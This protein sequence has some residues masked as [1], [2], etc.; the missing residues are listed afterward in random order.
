MV[1]VPLLNGTKTIAMKFYLF[2]FILF[3]T[4]LFGQSYQ[5]LERNKNLKKYKSVK[6]YNSDGRKGW[7]EKIT[8]KGGRIHSIKTYNRSLL[9]HKAVYHFDTKGNLDYEI[10]KYNSNKGKVNDT[11]KHFNVYNEA[12]QLIKMGQEKRS[13]FTH[14][15]LPQLIERNATAF[16]SVFGYREE[17]TYDSI[18]NIRQHKI[19]TKSDDKFEIE[20]Q[21]FQYDHN[22]NVIELN[23]SA[24]PKQEY[25]IIMTGGRDHYENEKFRYVY[26]KDN[27]WVEKYWIIHNKEY[28]IAT[29]K[30]K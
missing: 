29:R 12:G 17:I 9:T 28:L 6:V 8:L 13:Q 10:E 14:Q 26:N 3:T 21:Q 15:N 18:G 20:I 7:W 24:I 23:R 11:V 5:E 1:S 19:Y 22:N 30:F 4:Y 25:P 27:L 16:D 2:H